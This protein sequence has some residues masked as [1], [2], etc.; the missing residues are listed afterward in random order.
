MGNR[1]DAGRC[2]ALLSGADDIL[3]LC[4][5]DPDGD[6]LGSAL[7]LWYVLRQMGKRVRLECASALPENLAFFYPQGFGEEF[8]PQFIVAVDVASLDMLG[9]LEQ[10]YPLVDLCIDHH[11]TNPLYAKE[12][13]VSHDAATGETVLDVIRAMRQP[14]TKEA[15]TALLTAVCSDTGGF[16]FSNTTSDTLRKGADLLEAGADYDT[17]RIRL[18]E[19]KPRGLVQVEAYALQN[20]SYYEDGRIAVL[21]IPYALLL[22]A[23]V[24]EEQLEG[25]ASIP[26]EIQGVEIGITLKEKQDGSIR[27]SVR[28]AAPAD[29][30]AICTQFGGGGHKRAAGCRMLCTL[31]EAEQK[32]SQAAREVL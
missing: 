4:H 2:A 28:T 11:P 29:A 18:F 14:L 5:R 22:E 24:K 6:T 20:L 25:V 17:I 16:R 13:L 3:L 9:G 32:L 26:R 23:G 21:K 15:A 30:A 31:E 27:V 1:A 19:S 10:R 12:N 8:E 7:G